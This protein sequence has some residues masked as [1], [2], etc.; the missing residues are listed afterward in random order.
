MLLVGL[1]NVN[2]RSRVSPKYLYDRPITYSISFVSNLIFGG[3]P[4]LIQ[5][6]LPVTIALV[7]C[8]FMVSLLLENHS[9][10]LVGLMSSWIFASVGEVFFPDKKMTVSSAHS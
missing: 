9:C 3:L 8:T 10:R 2:V 6:L 1:L 5:D 7:F 4:F